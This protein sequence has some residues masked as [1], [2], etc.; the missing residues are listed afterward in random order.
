ML[1]FA[2]VLDGLLDAWDYGLGHVHGFAPSLGAKGEQPGGMFVASG[3]GGAVLAN[4]GFLD[5]GQG[6]FSRRPEGGDLPL[7][8]LLGGSRV[9]HM[10]YV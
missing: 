10:M 9:V 6:A 8:F 5:L 7:P 4:A 3:A 1:D 2:S